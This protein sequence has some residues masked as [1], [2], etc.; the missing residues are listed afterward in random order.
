M[1]LIH[2]NLVQVSF[3]ELDY[4]I[5]KKYRIHDLLHEIILSKAQELNLCQ[6]LDA[7]DTT[8]HGKSQRLS[9]HDA[10]EN[11]FESSEY[12]RVRSIFLF[13]ITELPRSF[14]VKLFKKFKLL[15]VLDFEDAPIDY[16]PQEVG[17]LF[18]LKH[19]SLRRTKV[20]ILPKSVGALH[21]LKTLNVLET[22][23][24]ELPIEIFRLYKLRQILAHSHDFEIESSLYS[25]R[26]VKV[27]EGVGC[28]KELQ[29]LSM[30]EANHHGV[31]L[32][33]ELEKL[34]QLRLL[35]ISNMT[36]ER[37]RVLCTSIQKMVLLN[38]LVVGSISEDEIIDLESISSPPPFLKHIY[39]RGRLNKLP[40]WILELQNLPDGGED[41]WKVKKVTT[42]RL[43]YRIKGEQY[44]IYKLGDLD[45]LE[46]LQGV[47]KTCIGL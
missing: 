25:E 1:E 4:E 9:I 43:R 29:E 40:N 23:V 2:R 21:N 39:L 17:N 35:G 8:S 3:G 6:V 42:I 41:Y 19:L 45:L 15:K 30:I 27:H 38:I 24:G 10:T 36:A 13:N 7:D 33:E 20:K 37:G 12:S 18:H 46:R 11:V 47:N 14:I 44:Q 26:G 34:S 16:L 28:L 5:Y 22:L 32:F 31:G